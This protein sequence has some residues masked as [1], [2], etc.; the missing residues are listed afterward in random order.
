MRTPRHPRLVLAVLLTVGAL[1]VVAA[2]VAAPRLDTVAGSGTGGFAGDGGAATAALLTSPSDVSPLPGGGYL[3]ADTSN[4][5][6]RRVAADGTITTVAGA[7][8][9][10]GQTGGFA[11]D[12]QPATSTLVRLNQPR[13]VSVTADGGFLIADTTNNVI[14]RVSPAGNHHDG[15]RDRQPGRAD[16]GQRAR[17]GRAAQR[18]PRRCG[19]T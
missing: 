18:S 8:P 4:H 13:G 10:V 19:D 5:R 2:A 3:I 15:C 1:V 16:R 7:G 14:R 17:D 11:G 6:I 12:G 9:A